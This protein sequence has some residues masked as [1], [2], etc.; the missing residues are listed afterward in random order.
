M[1]AVN[2]LIRIS[3]GNRMHSEAYSKSMLRASGSA[4]GCWVTWCWVQGLKERGIKAWP[5]EVLVRVRAC[6]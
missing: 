5:L 4:P 6:H 2:K 1:P 3:S